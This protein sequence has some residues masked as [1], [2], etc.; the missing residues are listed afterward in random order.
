MKNKP[1]PSDTEY[2]IFGERISL[3]NLI[4][5]GGKQG[6][7]AALELIEEV[8]QQV[9]DQSQEGEL[10]IPDSAMVRSLSLIIAYH[11]IGARV[12]AFKRGVLAAGPGMADMAQQ[13]QK[14]ETEIIDHGRLHDADAIMEV[15][16]PALDEHMRK[17]GRGSN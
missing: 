3:A 9:D 4:E 8:A 10:G 1:D 15:M 7:M 17:H 16:Q 2:T 13:I 6:G 12:D 5:K 14:L 11:W